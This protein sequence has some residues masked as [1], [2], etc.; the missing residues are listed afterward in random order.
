VGIDVPMKKKSGVKGQAWA[1]EYQ[2]KSLDL[3]YLK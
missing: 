2:Q 3:P 1:D